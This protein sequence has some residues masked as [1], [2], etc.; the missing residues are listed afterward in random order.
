MVTLFL[1]CTEINVANELLVGKCKF[2]F[3]IY[4][5]NHEIIAD[6]TKPNCFDDLM[7]CDTVVPQ[8]FSIIF[9][10]IFIF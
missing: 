3:I 5:S 2:Y 9:I 1:G 8:T 6:N 10:F 7:D 4:N